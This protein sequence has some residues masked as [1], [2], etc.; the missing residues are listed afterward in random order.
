MKQ[1]LCP[2]SGTRERCSVCSHSGRAADSGLHSFHRGQCDK[3][4]T[5]GLCP[6]CVEVKV[7]APPLTILIIRRLYT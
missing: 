4:S 1:M 2:A 6:K 3:A 5:C 7:V